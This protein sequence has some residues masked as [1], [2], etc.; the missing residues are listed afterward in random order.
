MKTI[1]TKSGMAVNITVAAI[2]LIQGYA[3]EKR[4]CKMVLLPC[5]DGYSGEARFL[6]GYDK[7]E[8]LEFVDTLDLGAIIVSIHASP[9]IEYLLRRHVVDATGNRLVMVPRPEESY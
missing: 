7:P 3:N 4:F 9:E 1:R 2:S 6:V 8:N 5:R